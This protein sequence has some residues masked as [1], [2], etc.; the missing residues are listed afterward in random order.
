MKTR[1]MSACVGIPV[2]AFLLAFSGPV[3]AQQVWVEGKVTDRQSAGEI[4]H[5]QLDGKKVYMLMKDCRIDMRFQD[6]PGAFNEKPVDFG[7]VRKGQRI[8]MK[9]EDNR[10]FQVLI[11]E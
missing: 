5:I 3:F 11:L 8:T 7:Y 10:V 9:V 1:Y 2:M 4:R 6:R